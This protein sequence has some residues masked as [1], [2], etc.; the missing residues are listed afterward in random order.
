[1]DREVWWATIWY[2]TTWVNRIG[3]STDI[4]LLKET[5]SPLVDK[6]NS[7]FSVLTCF[8]LVSSLAT[9]NY[10][11]L[12]RTKSLITLDNSLLFTLKELIYRGSLLPFFFPLFSNMFLRSQPNF[13]PSWIS[14]LWYTCLTIQ[15]LFLPGWI[16]GTTPKTQPTIFPSKSV[17]RPGFPNFS[18]IQT[19][20]KGDLPFWHWE[21]MPLLFHWCYCA[22]GSHH[23]MPK[24]PQVP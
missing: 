16:I 13:F 8:A 17:L 15:W 18:I 4:F 23:P 19:E 6:L 12:Y 21:H 5:N 10:M 1:M 3:L 20:N 22:S 24:P 9:I 7:V 11:G 2:W 14:I